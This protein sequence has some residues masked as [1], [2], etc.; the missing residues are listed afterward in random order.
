MTEPTGYRITPKSAFGRR[1]GGAKGA[2]VA[3]AAAAGVAAV[4]EVV[5]AV[6]VWRETMGLPRAPA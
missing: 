4:D 3:G 1:V 2:V 5:V 6:Q